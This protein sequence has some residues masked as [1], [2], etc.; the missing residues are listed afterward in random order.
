[1]PTFSQD[2]PPLLGSIDAAVQHARTVVGD[3]QPD[4]VDDAAKIVRALF[5]DALTRTGSAG[6][7]SLITSVNSSRI[8]FEI[9]DPNTPIPGAT[10]DPDAHRLISALADQYGS[11]GTRGGHVAWAELHDR[12]AAP[13]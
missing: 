10:L 8:R 11:G 3:Q 5:V 13:V 12:Q 6:N 2:Y 9:H 4:R 1:M 7:I